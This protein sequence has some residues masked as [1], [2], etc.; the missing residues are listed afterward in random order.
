MDTTPDEKDG[1]AVRLSSL[2]KGHDRLA[3]RIDSLE[4]KMGVVGGYL[5]F[6]GILSMAS[7][8]V[9]L[10][11]TA[12]FTPYLISGVFTL[13]LGFITMT[14]GINVRQADWA[15]QDPS[16]PMP[17]TRQD[18][19]ISSNPEAN[20]LYDLARVHS[21]DAWDDANEA[22]LAAKYLA[23]AIALDPAIKQIAEKDETLSQL[24]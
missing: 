8:V 12:G 17:T 3:A 20:K 24:L 10:A 2:E 11:V 18:V 23:D 5:V 1:K 14:I 13:V 19:P 6:S 4:R 16:P 7:G 15:P 9:I 22:T 21:R